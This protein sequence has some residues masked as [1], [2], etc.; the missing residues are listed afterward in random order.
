MLRNGL[1]CA[2]YSL[3]HLKLPNEQHGETELYHYK[4]RIS[5]TRFL[6]PVAMQVILTLEPS[7]YG[8]SIWCGMLVPLSSRI[9]SLSGG[10]ETHNEYIVIKISDHLAVLSDIYLIK[11]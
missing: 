9:M 6:P 11:K 10:T 2:N 1:G 5:Q 3:S 4:S 8:P 7:L